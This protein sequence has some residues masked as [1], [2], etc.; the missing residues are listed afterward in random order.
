MTNPLFYIEKN[1][2]TPPSLFEIVPTPLDFL[3]TT[4]I[5][6]DIQSRIGIPEPK[7]IFSAEDAIQKSGYRS[8]APPPLPPPPSITE[9]LPPPPPTNP[10]GQPSIPTQ[11]QVLPPKPPPLPSPE[12]MVP[13]PPP[14]M[15]KIAEDIERKIRPPSLNDL[16]NMNKNNMDFITPNKLADR[17]FKPP[18]LEETAPNPMEIPA[19]INNVLVRNSQDFP[20]DAI[21]ADVVGIIPIAGDIGDFARLLDPDNPKKMDGWNMALGVVDTFVGFI[22][23]IGDLID[24]LIPANTIQYLRNN[25]VRNLI[26]TEV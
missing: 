26:P 2:T 22:P 15:D 18:Q 13:P 16:D 21:G 19:R 5:P 9:V 14:G 7:D 1:A 12:Q 25:S 17:V 8:P 23:G 24:L 4:G 11:E 20:L 10:A 6:E 3:L